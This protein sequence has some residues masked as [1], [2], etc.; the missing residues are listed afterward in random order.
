[1]INPICHDALQLTEQQLAFLHILGCGNGRIPPELRLHL[2]GEPLASVPLPVLVL[3][4]WQTLFYRCLQ[5]ELLLRR[6]PTQFPGLL[7]SHLDVLWE[8]P[9]LLSGHMLDH[10]PEKAGGENSL[11]KPKHVKEIL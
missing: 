4:R 9:H 3:N 5:R 10:F 11:K 6:I 2:V 1:M 8:A 7:K